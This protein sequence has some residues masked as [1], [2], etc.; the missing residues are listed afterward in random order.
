MAVLHYQY[1]AGNVWRALLGIDMGIG[2]IWIMNC[3]KRRNEFGGG[4][5]KL[6]SL[7]GAVIG[8][9]VIFIFLIAFFL[10]LGFRKI[11]KNYKTL[12]FAPF[13]TFG[14]LLFLFLNGI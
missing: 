8:W 10:L 13:I 1:Y 11:T 3:L 12:P 14:T 7:I 4:D 5:A 6:L 9:K 2:I